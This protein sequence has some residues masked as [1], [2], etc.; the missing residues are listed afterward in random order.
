MRN[1]SQW[2]VMIIL[3]ALLVASIWYC[4]QIWRTTPAM[5]P[6]GNVVMSLAALVMVVFG[7]GLI[8]LMYFSGRKGLDETARMS[9]RSRKW[10]PV[11]DPTPGQDS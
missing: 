1:R 3:A 6:Y 7:S 4:L 9:R 10:R 11:R 5:P 8:A 2:F